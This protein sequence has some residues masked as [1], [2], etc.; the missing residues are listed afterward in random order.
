ML[1]A[2][3]VHETLSKLFDRGVGINVAR[4]MLDD[5]DIEILPVDAEQAALG[6]ALREAT[7]HSGLSLG[8]RSGL[9]LAGEAGDGAD[10]RSGLKGHFDNLSLEIDR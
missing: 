9:A 7:R 4:A 5:L 6:A 3:Y 2:V 8:D 10:D 1:C